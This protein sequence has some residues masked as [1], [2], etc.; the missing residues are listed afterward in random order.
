MDQLV[1]HSLLSNPQLIRPILDCLCLF[2][3]RCEGQGDVTS[4]TGGSGK[5][6]GSHAQVV[7]LAFEHVISTPS[8][9]LFP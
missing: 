9:S 5:Q 8:R 1:Q 7:R 4:T 6:S 2:G 3:L